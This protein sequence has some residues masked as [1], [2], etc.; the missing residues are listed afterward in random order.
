MISNF[1][2]CVL[3]SDEKHENHLS[4]S[5]I[6][7]AEIIFAD[8]I[9]NNE[10]DNEKCHAEI[11]RIKSEISNVEKKISEEKDKYNGALILNLKKDITI[12]KLSQQL[13]KMTYNE[14]QNDFSVE[15]IANFKSIDQSQAKDT[16][17]ILTALKDL[18]AEDLTKLKE[19][20]YSGRRK[21][22]VTPMKIKVLE[23]LFAKRIQN[24]PDKEI[25]GKSLGK[26]IKNAIET[27][28]RNQSL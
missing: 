6:I 24:D 26:C 7:D 19:R 10:C 17:F 11:N 18:Y 1:N 13:E 21:K 4:V 2:Y 16:T 22:P 27:I 15:A 25:R 28:N 14:F 12:E 3:I 9:E 20:T 23:K 5:H 8:V